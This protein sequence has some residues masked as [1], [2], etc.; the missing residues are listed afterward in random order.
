MKQ[1]LLKINQSILFFDLLTVILVFILGLCLASYLGLRSNPAGLFL[2]WLSFSLL[3]L[4]LKVMD[5]YSLRSTQLD[6]DHTFLTSIFRGLRKQNQKTEK[7]P[8]Y[9]GL[10]LLL[11]LFGSWAMIQFVLLQQKLLPLSAL[12]LLALMI[13]TVLL[14][15]LPSTNLIRNGYAELV[16]AL[17]LFG[18]LPVYAILVISGEFHILLILICCPLFLFYFSWRII[19]SLF[20]YTD[21]QQCGRLNFLQRLGW[22]RGMT[23]HNLF[24]L[25]GF[26]FYACIPLFGYPTAIFLNPLLALPLGLLLILM[27]FRIERG[28]KPEWN[29]MLLLEK[30]FILLVVYFLAAGMILR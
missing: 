22:K 8:V 23:A 2:G 17:L 20:R 11:I 4:G 16:Q 26:V 24:I 13:L 27:I 15:G 19:Y 3:V 12:F 25:F 18:L 9:L 1:T 29:S 7:A 21:D 5:F 6:D 30:I 28:K 10:N 14:A